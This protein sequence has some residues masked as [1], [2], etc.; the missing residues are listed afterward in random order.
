MQYSCLELKEEDDDCLNYKN[1]HFHT[2]SP[3]QKVLTQILKFQK[4]ASENIMEV[5]AVYFHE[6]R[7]LLVRR[8]KAEVFL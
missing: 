7:Y 3:F 6:M 5:D 2:V 1:Y 4:F 8:A